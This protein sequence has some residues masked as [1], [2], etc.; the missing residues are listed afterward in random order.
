MLCDLLAKESQDLAIRIQV[1]NVHLLIDASAQVSLRDI[2]SAALAIYVPCIEH[3]WVHIPE[4]NCLVFVPISAPLPPP[5]PKS[6]WS[7]SSP[8]LIAH[9][10][11]HSIQ[12]A[13]SHSYMPLTI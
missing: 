3:S 4:A 11:K 5:L 10:I 6:Q 8:H 7:S 1:A 12:W 9:A 13:T 2:P